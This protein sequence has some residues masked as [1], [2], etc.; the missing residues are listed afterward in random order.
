MNE[1]RGDS[2]TVTSCCAYLRDVIRRGLATDLR[3]EPPN[4]AAPPPQETFMKS[5]LA[6]FL[7]VAALGT[8]CVL[9]QEGTSGPPRALSIII[10]NPVPTPLP[11]AG[12]KLV[13]PKF[14]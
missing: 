6:T 10:A 14:R 3:D 11:A 2:G 12:T 9:A 1:I 7:L 4:A 5:A 13:Q 8:T